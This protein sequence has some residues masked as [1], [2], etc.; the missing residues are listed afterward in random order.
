MSIPDRDFQIWNETTL[1]FPIIKRED[2]AGKS[3]DK[4][5][6]LVFGNLRLGQNRLYPVDVRIGAG[7]DYKFN[8]NVSFTPTYLYRRGEPLRNVK[9]FEHRIRFDLTVGNKWKNFSIRDRNRVEYR[10]RN[11]RPNSVRYRNRLTF[12]VPIK[13]GGKELFSPFVADEI[14]YDFSA[15]KITTN[16]FTAGIT[17]QI[18]KD[19]TADIYYLRRDILF[20]QGLAFNGIAVNLKFRID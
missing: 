8:Q 10:V 16:E 1:Q 2:K 4:L 13:M 19:T 15:K 17:R 20:L 3:F 11:S 14:Y 6:L 18:N 7:F 12:A 5:S 9:E